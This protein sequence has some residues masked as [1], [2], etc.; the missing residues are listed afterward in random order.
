M[1]VSVLLV[2]PIREGNNFVVSP[3]LG[4]LYLGSALRAKGFDVTLL[5]CP[6]K[7]FTFVDFKRFLEEKRFDV[8][9]VRCFTR[10]H[11]YVKHHVK[12]AKHVN[13]ETITLTG[14]PHP[15]ALPD[16]LLRDM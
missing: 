13:P 7:N 6:K 11:N 4:V 2:L 3:D 14:G 10:D 5:D 12:I 16:Y 1:G 8:V 9:G 15:S